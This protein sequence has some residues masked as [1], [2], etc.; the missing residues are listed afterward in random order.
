M[1]ICQSVGANPVISLI[2]QSVTRFE[3]IQRQTSKTVDKE[4]RHKGNALISYYF[5]AL[6]VTFI[7]SFTYSKWT[8]KLS[9]L[10]RLWY[11][12]HRRPAKAQAS[13]RIRTV[14]PEPSLFAHMKYGS[15]RM[16]RPKIRNLA[17]LDGCACRL[18]N[19]FTE[20]EKYHNLMRR[21]KWTSCPGSVNTSSYAAMVIIEPR[22]EKTCRQGLR[23]GKTQTSLRSQRS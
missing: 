12:S 18:K 11:L 22:H 23:P 20:D 3:L 9:Q 13:L 10:M 14:S 15:R 1:G 8:L 19:E 16:V 17:P 2:W 7:S 6:K 21:L 4:R 5:R